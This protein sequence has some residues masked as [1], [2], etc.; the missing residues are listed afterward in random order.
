MIDLDELER[1]MKAADDAGRH[2]WI[3]EVDDFAFA[4]R[5]AAPQLIALARAGS[6]LYEACQWRDSTFGIVLTVLEKQAK[7]NAQ[8][9]YDKAL[10]AFREAQQGP[11]GD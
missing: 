7:K 9:E 1:M 11:T 8:L 5:D 6:R 3:R 10:A 2:R 4:I